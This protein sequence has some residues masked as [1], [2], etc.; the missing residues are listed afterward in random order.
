MAGGHTHVQM[1]RRHKD[2]MIFNVGSVGEPFERYPSSEPRILPWAEYAIIS[3]SN[4]VLGIELRR[5]P[6]DFDALKQAT[7][8]SGNPFNWM[9]YW[10]PPELR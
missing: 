5:V 1:V 3:W 4:G 9:P 7:M 8:T 6:I 2:A 10:F